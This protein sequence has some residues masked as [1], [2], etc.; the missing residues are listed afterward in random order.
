MSGNLIVTKN[1][2]DRETGQILKQYEQSRKY[3]DEEKGYLFISSNK[4]CIHILNLDILFNRDNLTDLEIGKLCRLSSRLSGENNLLIY[5]SGNNLKPMQKCHI[6]KFLNLSN[7]SCSRF[8]NKMQKEN[9]IK[10]VLLKKPNKKDEENYY[11]NPIYFFAGS[12]LSFLLYDL[13]AE[14][15]NRILPKWVIVKFLS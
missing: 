6:A 2:I 12:W 13:F 10:R 9:I 11:L 1:V 3:F 7:R 15:L 4:K 5:R 14:D 8:L